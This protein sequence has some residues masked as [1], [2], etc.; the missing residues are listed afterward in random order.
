MVAAG[1]L[2]A[3][4]ARVRAVHR[5]EPPNPVADDLDF[6]APSRRP[7]PADRGDRRPRDAAAVTDVLRERPAW[8][9]DPPLAPERAEAPA[10]PD[11]QPGRSRPRRR[12]GAG[13]PP[14]HDRLF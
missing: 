3:A 9:G 12:G 4:G 13:D 2:V 14:A 10:A 11:P 1:A 7:R 5:P 8:E 6:A